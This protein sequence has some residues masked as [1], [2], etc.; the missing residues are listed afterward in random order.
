MGPVDLQFQLSVMISNHGKAVSI[1]GQ[2]TQLQFCI[3]ISLPAFRHLMTT[4]DAGA[5]TGSKSELRC[6]KVNSYICGHSFN[7]H[8]YHTGNYF[9]NLTTTGLEDL[10]TSGSRHGSLSASIKWC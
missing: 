7:Y 3:R 6:V 1:C 9:T 8:R 10:L 4:D 2:Q 5:T